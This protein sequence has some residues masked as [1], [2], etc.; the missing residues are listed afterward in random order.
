LLPSQVTWEPLG[1]RLGD[2]ALSF[3]LATCR[4]IFGSSSETEL[5]DVRALL[6]VP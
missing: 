5:D 3:L 2:D 1:I 4:K 6:A